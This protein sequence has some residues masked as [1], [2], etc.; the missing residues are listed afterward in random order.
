MVGSLQERLVP[1]AL[2]ARLL[3]AFAGM[4]LLPVS[5]ALSVLWP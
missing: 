5:L 3:V 2:L 4:S 1:N